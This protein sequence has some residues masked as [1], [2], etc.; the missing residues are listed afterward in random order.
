ML[1]PISRPRITDPGAIP[2]RPWN[3]GRIPRLVLALTALLSCGPPA[4][5]DGDRIRPNDPRILWMGRVDA[6]DPMHPR[7][8]YPGVT[9]RLRFTGPS[10]HG[11]FTSH[12]GSNYFQVSVNGGSPSLLE[13]P[14][15]RHEIALATA[16]GT[17]PHTVDIVKATETWQGTVALVGFRLGPGGALQQPPPLPERKLLI[18]GD[19]VTCGAEINRAPPCA[20]RPPT[21]KASPYDSYGMRLARQLDA[22]VHLVCFGGRGLI[23]D[24]SGRRNVMDARRFYDLSVPDESQKSPPVWAHSVYTP[25]AVIVSLGTNDFNLN[26]GHLPSREEYVSAY[27]QFVTSIRADYPRALILLTE[28]AMLTDAW[29]PSLKPK[30]ALSAY[31]ADTVARLHDPRVVHTESVN[32]PGDACDSHP[33]REQH[34][35]MATDLRSVLSRHLGW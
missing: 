15:G 27:A 25:D 8:G 6:S 26:R 2:S 4:G 30:S 20:D 35:A 9:L 19:S 23:G 28:G 24:W 11:T 7:F 17:G 31:I 3:R 29:N 13:L 14:S 22:Q 32:Y 5:A 10:L 1:T 21:F 12:P 34:D 33:T 16:L 18:I